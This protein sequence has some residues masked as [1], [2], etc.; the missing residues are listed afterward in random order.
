MFLEGILDSDSCY[1]IEQAGDQ[2][3]NF[4]NAY[5]LIKGP[6]SFRRQGR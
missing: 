1:R 3:E 6:I 2:A 4:W 5:I